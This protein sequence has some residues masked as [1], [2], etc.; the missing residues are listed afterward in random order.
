MY[1]SKK[2]DRKQNILML[3]VVYGTMTGMVIMDYISKNRNADNY[4]RKLQAEGK[5]KW[6]C[7]NLLEF[8]IFAVAV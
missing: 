5:C 4:K 3:F 6:T 8:F 1:V 2:R 7:V